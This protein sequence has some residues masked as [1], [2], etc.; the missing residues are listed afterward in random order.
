MNMIANYVKELTMYI[1]AGNLAC[2]I[3]VDQKNSDFLKKRLEIIINSKSIAEEN[4]KLLN[5]VISV[6]KELY[7]YCDKLQLI[8]S[9]FNSKI[10]NTTKEELEYSK[11]IWTEFYQDICILHKEIKLITGE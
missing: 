9:K 1:A 5:K 8:F 4:I 2:R 10:N 11:D 3:N 7:I 6:N